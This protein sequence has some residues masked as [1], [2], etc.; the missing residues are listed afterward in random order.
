VSLST[1][2]PSGI[3]ASI[4]SPTQGVW[5][6]GPLPVRAYALFILLGIL[7]AVQLGERRWMQRGGRPGVVLDIAAWAVPFGIVGGRLYHVITSWQPYFGSDGDPIKALYIWE[8]GLGIWGAV[9]LG[10]LG[11]WIGARRAGVLLPPM[12]D[13]LAPGIVLAQAIGRWGNWF[14]NELYGSRTDLP[15]GLRIYKWDQDAG[16]AVNGPDGRPIVLGTFHP[17]FLYESLWD[18]GVAVALLWADRRWRLGHGRVFALYVLLYTL[19]RGWI[20]ALRID[21]ANKVLGL[22]VNLW[23]SLVVGLTAL[24]L[25]VWSARRRPGRERVVVRTDAAADPLDTGTAAGSSEDDARDVE[26][27]T[28]VDA[29]TTDPAPPVTKPEPEPAPEPSAKAEP[30]PKPAPEPSAKA[31][32]KPAPEPS[33]KAEP[34]P[35]PK[36][37]PEPKLSAKSGPKADA[38]PKAEPKATKPVVKP[39]PKAEPTPD[40]AAKPEPEP[41]V[42]P[43][44][45]ANAARKPGAKPE[46]KAEKPKLEPEAEKP[47]AKAEKPEPEAEKPEPEAEKSKAEPKAEKPELEPEPK[48]VKPQ[49]KAT[50][51]PEPRTTEPKADEPGPAEPKQEPEPGHTADPEVADASTS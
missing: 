41:A 10:G 50:E 13:A 19:G 20:E 28:V 24:S 4:P 44:P 26:P 48:A 7:I 38:E 34:K 39:P 33:A 2:I 29:V 1:S 17:T 22:R 42:T 31:G 36:P 11:A 23:T 12:A 40:A 15:W 6:A 51:K 5:Y 21:D 18:V 25:L 3:V 27:V 16:H 35:E 49:P 14:N 32:P 47:D 45:E 46:P 9:A 8:G 43:E 30:K 37:E